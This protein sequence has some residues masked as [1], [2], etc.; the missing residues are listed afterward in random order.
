M[1]PEQLARELEVERAQ[2]S[3]PSTPAAPG[4]DR[5][6]LEAFLARVRA[7]HGTK[8]AQAM[9]RLVARLRAE[10]NHM[11]FTAMLMVL[12]NNAAASGS[13]R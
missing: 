8:A 3:P 9:K 12:L 2:P 13:H 6:L 1:T 4:S 5:A 7:D 11:T 10:S